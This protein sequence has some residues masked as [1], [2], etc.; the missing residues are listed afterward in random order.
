[1]A[2]PR[3]EPYVWV[4]WITRLLAGE[5]NCEW[6][7][8]FRAH[9]KYEK[10]PPETDF[11]VRNARHA[12]LVRNRIMELEADGFTVYQEDQNTFSLPGRVV[13]LGGRPDI[14]AVKGELGLVVDCKTGV[15]KNSDH[16]QILTYMLVLPLVN[17]VCKGRSLSGEITYS[18]HAVR[19]SPG[20]LDSEVRRLITTVLRR[21][22]DV[23]PSRRVPGYSECRFCDISKA[24]CADR[25]EAAPIAGSSDHDL[26]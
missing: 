17:A 22:G 12:E 18:D 19:L 6:A 9:Y 16:F 1:M 13:T 14:I 2:M 5:A 23:E 4:T 15:K 8:W 20:D 25:V 7:L 21:A 3:P 26:F 24:D 11:A 10:L